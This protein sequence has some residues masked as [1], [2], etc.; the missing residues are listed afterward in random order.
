M[1]TGLS[2]FPITPFKNEH[3]DHNAFVRIIENLV[4]ANVESICAMGST[5]LYPYLTREQLSELTALAVDKAIDIPVMVGVGA[6][7]TY[8]V[9]HNV[10]AV[11]KA[12]AN[13]VLLAPVSY[14]PLNEN[15]VFNLYSAVS[16][17]V[18][19]PICVYENPRVTNFTFSDALYRRIAKLQN[20]GAIK[21]PGMPF[22]TEQGAERLAT[23]RGMLPEHIAIG[24]SGDAFGA[25]GMAEGCDLWLSVIGGMFPK[26]VKHIIALTQ[27]D[28]SADAHAVSQSLNGVW[29]LFTRNGGGL[30]V[31]AAAADILGF[32]EGNSLPS[33]FLPISQKDHQAL[34]NLI[35]KL[36]LV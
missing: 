3:I 17:E 33:P 20:I 7:R 25:K 36:D 8:D 2:A 31:M 9:L 12:G 5:G 34:Y 32:C 29:E 4:S 26:T 15:E 30:R 6:L 27:S 1:F 24:V 10:E 35:R 22:A 21:I 16:R 23:L 13:A 14:H 19:V 18:S 11:Q 28:E